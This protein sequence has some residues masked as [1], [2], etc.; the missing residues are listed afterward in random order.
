MC[1]MGFQHNGRRAPCAP[2]R[3]RECVHAVVMRSYAVGTRRIL[4]RL[5]AWTGAGRLAGPTTSQRPSAGKFDSGASLY[6]SDG[7]YR[8]HVGRS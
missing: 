7:A 5:C 8:F 4:R 6:G 2:M 3:F 1:D